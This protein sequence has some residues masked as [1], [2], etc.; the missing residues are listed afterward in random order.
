MC[1]NIRGV[2]EAVSLLVQRHVG[3]LYVTYAVAF[4]ASLTEKQKSTV[5]ETF[6]PGHAIHE[7]L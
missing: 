3:D 7:E 1:F 5:R 4:P 2:A 6:P